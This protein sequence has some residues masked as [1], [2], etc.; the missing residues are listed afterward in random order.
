MY[1]YI[2]LT[3]NKING[4]QYVGQHAKR[5]FDIKYKGSGK[6]L[7]K[8]FKKYGKENFECHIIDTAESQEELNDKE[9]VYIELYQTLETGY[10]LCEGGGS[11]SGYK[12]TDETKQK[13]GE[14]NKGRCHTEESKQK[15]SENHAD[16]SGE[17]HPMYGRQHTEE[18][19]QKMRENRAD[20]S[21]EKNPMHGRTG[22]KH[23]KAKKCPYKGIEF[24]SKTDAYNYAKDYCG[25]TKS[26]R[27]FC[28]QLKAGN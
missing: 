28:N 26:Y 14:A 17:K 25:Y 5:N 22:E 2:Y 4:K 3:T 23:P 6:T 1:G 7:L 8:A 15:M 18:S 19:K 27:T 13:I 12:H 20:I 11:V 10:N 16:F 24:G 21:G 9:F